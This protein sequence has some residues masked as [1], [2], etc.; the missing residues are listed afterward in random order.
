MARTGRVDFVDPAW[1]DALRSEELHSR[2][3]I[4]PILHPGGTD[5][6]FDVK[7]T[8]NSRDLFNVSVNSPLRSL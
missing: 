2:R 8:T 7:Q 1:R 5:A 6:E 4:Q 3:D